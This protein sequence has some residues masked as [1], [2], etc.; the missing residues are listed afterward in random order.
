MLIVAV[1]WGYVVLMM[2]VAEATA[3]NGTLL[4]AFFTLLLYGLLPMGVVLYLM[5]TPARRRLKRRRDADAAGPASTAPDQRGHAAG[6]AVAPE[7]KE[8]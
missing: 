7:R 3:P 4:G 8:T 6:D 2:A 1:A 5:A